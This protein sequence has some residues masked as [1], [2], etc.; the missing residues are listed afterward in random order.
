MASMRS[1]KSPFEFFLKDLRPKMTLIGSSIYF[2]ISVETEA[3]CQTLPV[4]FV[5]ETQAFWTFTSLYWK[6][7]VYLQLWF[8]IEYLGDKMKKLGP[9]QKRNLRSCKG[10]LDIVMILMGLR[11]VYWK[12]AI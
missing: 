10:Y 4:N 1:E 9:F 6:Q 5:V 2:L 8:W 3:Y 12:L 11:E 7:L